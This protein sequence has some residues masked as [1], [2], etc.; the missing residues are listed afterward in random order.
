MDGACSTH[1]SNE[2]YKILVG[3]LEGKRQLRRPGHSREYNRMDLREMRWESTD[4]THLAG[5]S[6]H[7]NEPWGSIKGSDY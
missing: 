2:K 6:E 7:G 5:S 1:E 3:I 4:W